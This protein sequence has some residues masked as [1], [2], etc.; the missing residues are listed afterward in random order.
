[1][2]VNREPRA[3][4]LDEKNRGLKGND[5]SNDILVEVEHGLPVFKKTLWS[6]LRMLSHLDLSHS[7]ILVLPDAL[8]DL[9]G[10]RFL[11]A[12]HN[13]LRLLPSSV[14]QLK[15][16]AK[17]VLTFNILSDLPPSFAELN[18]LEYL[19]VSNNQFKS[20]PECFQM[21]CIKI[22]HFD[23]SHNKIEEWSVGPMCAYGMKTFN[24][25]Y[26]C[27]KINPSWL[28]GDVCHSLED[29]DLS[30]NSFSN[31][32]HMIKTYTLWRTG[33]TVVLRNV[34]LN[35]CGLSTNDIHLL[36]Q[37][38]AVQKLRL[39]NGK[40]NGKLSLEAKSNFLWQISFKP[41]QSCASLTELYISRVGLASLPEDISCLDSLEI[42]DC[43]GNY[44][45]WLPDTF[46]Q[47]ANLR[48]AVL[49]NNKVL[50]LPQNFGNLISLEE[51]RLDYNAMGELPSSFSNLKNLK[52]LDLYFNNFEEFP[53]CIGDVVM[54]L[55]GFDLDFNRLESS[56]LINKNV[57][58]YSLLRGAMCDHI[59]ATMDG[60]VCRNEGQ[61]PPTD[62]NECDESSESS[63]S[64]SESDYGSG[65][66]DECENL[67]P[68][69][70]NASE[71]ENWDLDDGVDDYFDPT[72]ETERTCITLP[73]RA[74]IIN[75]LVLHPNSFCPS[76]IHPSPSVRASNLDPLAP[77]E[78]QFDDA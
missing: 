6:T 73:K 44:I 27:L 52:F 56:L 9:S 26:N 60:K 42:F 47:L 32:A 71:E 29:L 57:D 18:N 70:D 8:G 61:R 65:L 54:N 4:S 75:E 30:F 16:L 23:I 31:L 55:A 28:W 53:V 17:L 58:T 14:G 34:N 37:L 38:K 7:N 15:G 40:V 67:E 33:V 12:S 48:I 24:C 22:S 66:L 50:F 11:G 59:Q 63:V 21:G 36:H 1:M 3:W 35:N 68:Q 10:L 77:Q 46:S 45:Q 72:Y 64:N 13:K 74:L 78:G 2:E 62:E 69:E 51:L 20:P 25:S 76:D 39:E 5:C 43:Q 19:D 49:S 41:F